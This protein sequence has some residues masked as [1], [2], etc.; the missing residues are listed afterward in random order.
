ME[1]LKRK[2]CPV[3]LPQKLIKAKSNEDKK[4]RN[5]NIMMS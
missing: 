4:Y 5:K 1:I 3:A 2:Y